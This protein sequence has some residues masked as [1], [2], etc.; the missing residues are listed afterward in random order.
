MAQ[1]AAQVTDE[2]V[3]LFANEI[4]RNL[5]EHLKQIILFGSRARGDFHPDS[6]YDFLIVVDK[7]TPRVKDI[8][9]EVSSEFLYEYDS[10][11]A[12][13]LVPEDT[14]QNATFNPLYRNVQREGIRL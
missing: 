2:L 11:F 5:G 4:R 6:D 7:L 10:V 9:N 3:T 12:A 13:I 8:V 1:Q 14:F